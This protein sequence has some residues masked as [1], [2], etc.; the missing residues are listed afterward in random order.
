MKDEI[1]FAIA[2]IGIY[3]LMRG[4]A[5]RA[6]GAPIDPNGLIAPVAKIPPVVPIERTREQN[7]EIRADPNSQ[8]AADI[9]QFQEE[10]AEEY[11]RMRR[12]ARNGIQYRYR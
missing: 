10:K 1:L 11:T 2:G 8:T 9:Q 7:R 6:Q 3:F 12:A 5:A 4:Q